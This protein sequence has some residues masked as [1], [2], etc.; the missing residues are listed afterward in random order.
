MSWRQHAT[1]WTNVD[2]SSGGNFTATR[3]ASF[4]YNEIE[5]DAF[6]ITAMFPGSQWIKLS[7]EPMLRNDINIPIDLTLYL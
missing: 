7:W 3:Q 1:N 6:E 5:S 4:L 2:Y